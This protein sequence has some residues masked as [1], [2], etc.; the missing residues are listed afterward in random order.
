MFI[1]IDKA[2]KALCNNTGFFISII[3]LLLLLIY[4]HNKCN[5]LNNTEQ[6]FFWD[7]HNITTDTN[8]STNPTATNTTSTNP[9]ATNTTATNTNTNPTATIPIPRPTATNLTDTLINEPP[10]DVRISINGNNITIIFTIKINNNSKIPKKF[11]VVLAQHDN[12][13]KN[14]GNNKIYLSNEYELNMSVSSNEKTYKTNLCTL[15][16]GIPSCTHTFNNVDIKDD[17][18]NLFYYKIGISSVYDNGNSAFVMPYNINT[19]NNLF[20][21][22]NSIEQQNNIVDEFN[23]FKQSQQAS[24]LL[25][26]NN[27]TYSNTMLTADGQYEIIKSQLGNYPSNLLMDPTSEQQNSLSD[28]VDKSLALGILNV[29][30]K[31]KLDEEDVDST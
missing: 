29:N 8:T 10:T 28:I 25:D 3:I 23:K 15:I 9:T 20:S 14:T 22:N 27:N 7:H 6:F 19:I 5:T 1:K 24:Q 2:I 13:Y 31:K 30:V 26:G 16:Q 18:G 4:S 21:L 11:I 17:N 12:N